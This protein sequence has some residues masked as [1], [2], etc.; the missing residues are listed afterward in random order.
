MRS[1]LFVTILA[2]LPVLAACN[3]DIAQAELPVAIPMT[4]EAVGHYCQMDILE[5][6]GPKAQV[7]LAHLREPLWFSQVRD[8]IAYLKS[9]EQDGEVRILYVNDMGTAKSWSE[10]GEASWI[11]ATEA[12]FVVGSNAIGGMG[13]PEIVPFAR[14]EKAQDFASSRGGAI[15]RLGDV[16][17][18]DVLS[19]IELVVS[20]EES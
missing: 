3:E 15:K 5:H 4:A 16:S 13:A 6:D 9:P 17:A 10:P 11:D 7:H 8:G 2:C 14:L 20:K 18:D 1:G 12:Y 19:P